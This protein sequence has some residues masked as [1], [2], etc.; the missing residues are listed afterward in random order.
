MADKRIKI[1]SVHIKNFRS[2][3]N[4]LIKA[5]DLNIFVGT[6]DVGKSNV[7]KAL[8][9]FFNGQTDYDKPFSFESDFTYLFPSKSHSTKEIKITITFEIPD[10]YSDAGEY[11]WTKVWRTDNYFEETILNKNGE[12]PN[13]KSRVSGALKRIKYRYVPAVKSPL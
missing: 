9:L 10:T 4:V 7:L 3:R 6:N 1:S 8:N 5:T 2:I 11:T 12:K 13:T